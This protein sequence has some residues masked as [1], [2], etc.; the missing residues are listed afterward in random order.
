M[1]L[2]LGDGEII[3]LAFARTIRKGDE[4]T[5]IIEL[6]GEEGKKTLP[7][8]T[9]PHRDHTFEKLV[10]NLSRLRLALK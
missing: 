3:N 7:F 10:E 8:P 1:W 4:A 2:R 9:E 6:S 5:I